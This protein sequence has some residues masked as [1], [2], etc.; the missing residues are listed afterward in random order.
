MREL[1]QNIA[2]ASWCSVHPDEQGEAM[3][4]G[5]GTGGKKAERVVG[6]S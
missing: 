5:A 1:A 6:I 3:R 2:L 4:L